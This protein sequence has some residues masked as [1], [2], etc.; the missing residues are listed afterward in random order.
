MRQYR[1]SK[2]LE[3]IEAALRAGGDRCP[4]SFAP[5]SARLA[6][7][8][9]RDPAVDDHESNRLFRQIV[10]RLDGGRGDE[11]EVT[12]AVFQK[13]VGHAE[14]QQHVFVQTHVL[15][16]RTPKVAADSHAKP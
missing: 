2:E 12:V 11:A 8:A 13:S 1:L 10:G 5:I 14:L 4:D 7:S 6:A 9:L 15:L 3:Y 16:V